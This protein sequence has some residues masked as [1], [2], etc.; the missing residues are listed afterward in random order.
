ML[1]KYDVDC[2]ESAQWE[3]KNQEY[4]IHAD[5]QIKGKTWEIQL[6]SHNS[7][8]SSNITDGWKNIKREYG[9]E[10]VNALEKEF[11]KHSACPE[12]Q[13]IMEIWQPLA[14]KIS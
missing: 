1:A 11:E 12:M 7:I 3:V 2:D 9:I 13:D 10:K 8:Y 6:E 14:K 5:I 4:R